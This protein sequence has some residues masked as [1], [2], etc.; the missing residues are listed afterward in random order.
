VAMRFLKGLVVFLLVLIVALI[1]V[2]FVL[3][4]SAHVER[5]VTIARPASEIFAI[6]NSYH[7]FN[8]W[9]PWVAKDPHAHYTVSGPAAGVGAKQSWIGDPKTVG[10]GSQEII[11]SKANESVTSALDF[12]DRGQAKAHFLLAPAG[13][14]TRVTWSL[15]TSAPLAFDGKIVRNTIGR[16]MGPFMDGMVGPDYEAGLAKLKTL[17]ETFP[18]VDISGV[19]GVVVQ[20]A[21]R[22]IYFISASSGTDPESAKAVLTMVYSKLGKYLADNGLKAVGPPLTVTT[23]YD[24]SG[25]KFDAAIPVD[26]NDAATREDIQAGT[27]YAG[28]AA[29]FMHVGPY[30][31][32]GD[33]TTKAFAWLAVQG[34]KAHDRLIEDYVS[35]PGNTPPE[36]LQT[37]L[38]IPIE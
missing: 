24:S 14:G 19:D 9:S 33:T 32:I 8:D 15:D 6:L 3:P 29:Q 27:T 28:R 37:R 21:P 4:P 13:H 16:Y 12:G 35:D 31:R 34:Y 7:R 2:A 26:R 11:E 18:D 36:Q 22:K 10:S 38:T 5:S 23:G 25:W 20:L 30:D 1:G 17:V